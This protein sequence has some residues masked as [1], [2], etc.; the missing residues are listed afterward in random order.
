[1]RQ[2]IDATRVRAGSAAQRIAWRLAQP[3]PQSAQLAPA[4]L[5]LARAGRTRQERQE[6]RVA[7]LAQSLAHLNPQAVL[8]RGYAIVTAADGA[9]VRD[10]ASLA[11]GDDVGIALARGSVGA[12]I[13]KR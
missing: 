11:V 12:K 2:R 9:I 1:M 4:A 8:D 6:A 3:L 13:T 10:A 7:T 5:A